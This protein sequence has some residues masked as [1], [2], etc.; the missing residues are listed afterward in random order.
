[1]KSKRFFLTDEQ[2]ILAILAIAIAA[3][4]LWAMGCGGG[5]GG[6]YSS[7]TTPSSSTSTSTPT[8]TT[9]TTPSTPAATTPAAAS[10]VTV[11]IVSSD[12]TQAFS[13]N[14]IKADAGSQIVWKNNSG[15]AHHLV[16]D[17]GAVIGDVNAGGSLTT[18]LSGSG[19]NFH[20]TIHPSMVG[21]IN[22]TLPTGSSDGSTPTD[23]Y[24]Y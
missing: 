11:T 23:P 14:P 18:T 7:P 8:T 4:A 5:G 22:G 24:A 19:G 10:G 1:M 16:M 9:T 3:V 15:S 13:P 2:T 21:S 17:S 6:A 12:G 20:C